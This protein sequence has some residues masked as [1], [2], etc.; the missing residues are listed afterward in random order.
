MNIDLKLCWPKDNIKDIKN[1]EKFEKEEDE[2]EE[3]SI[4]TVRYILYKKI[5]LLLQVYVGN[6]DDS[7]DEEDFI[8]Y[9]KS[10][11]ESVKS[12]IIIRDSHTGKSKGYGFINLSSYEDYLRLIKSSQS[13]FLNNKMLVIK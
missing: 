2:T 3:D 6:L 5:Y 9:F 4:F 11:C 7:L 13:Y 10:Y 1:L 8:N 12:G